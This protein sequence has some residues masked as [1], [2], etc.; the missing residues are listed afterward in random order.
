MEKQNAIDTNTLTF[1][2]QEWINWDN[3]KAD[4]NYT[5]INKPDEILDC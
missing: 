1:E 3:D 4:C 5:L 2:K